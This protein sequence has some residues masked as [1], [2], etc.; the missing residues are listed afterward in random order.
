MAKT[1][2]IV[3]Q[4]LAVCI[5]GT[6][7]SNRERLGDLIIGA[8]YPFQKSS[9]KFNHIVYTVNQNDCDAFLFKQHFQIIQAE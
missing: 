8:S 7:G 2:K 1:K 6:R 4:G 5:R 3:E 9:D